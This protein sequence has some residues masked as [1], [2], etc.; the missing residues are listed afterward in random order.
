[1]KET[2]ISSDQ[3]KEWREKQKAYYETHRKEWNEYQ[4]EYKRKRYAED[5]EYRERMLKYGRKYRQNK[6]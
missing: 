5:P 4:R 6:K 1:M 3:K 2:N